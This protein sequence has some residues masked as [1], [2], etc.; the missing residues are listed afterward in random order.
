MNK[1]NKKPTLADLT[2]K[3]VEIRDEIKGID[4]IYVEDTHGLKEEESQIKQAIEFTMREQGI[5]NTRFDDLA[6][7]TLKKSV[8][9]RIVDEP[10][11]VAHLKEKGLHDYVSE[12]VN[13]NFDSV[14]KTI[15]NTGESMPGVQIFESEYLSVRVTKPDDVNENEEIAK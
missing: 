15:E 10:A 2:R 4:L 3:L 6:T 1:M 14:K 11:L 5:S 9:A 12:R 13:Q 7:I 8:V